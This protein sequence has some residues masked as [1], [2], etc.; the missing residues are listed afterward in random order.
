MVILNN[1]YFEYI[2]LLF[3]IFVKY[4]VR[5]LQV[6]PNRLIIL[7]KMIENE[8]YYYYYYYY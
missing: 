8:I 1:V 6:Y 4:I 3:K 7:P 2:Q 5:I